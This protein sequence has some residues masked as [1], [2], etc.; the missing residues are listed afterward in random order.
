[1]KYLCLSIYILNYVFG[2]YEYPKHVFSAY[3]SVRW[4]S[5]NKD[6]GPVVQSI[7][8]LTSSL[9]R[10]LVKY[11]LTTLSNPLLFFFCWKNVR[12][13]CNAKDSHIFPTK[14]QQQWICNIYLLNFN[15]TLTNDAVNFEQLAPDCY[16]YW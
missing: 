10:Q 12:I 11:M 2:Q 3:C 4:L 15:I 14:K 8:S 1:M 7:V 6:L 5:S 9:R 16:F 13:F